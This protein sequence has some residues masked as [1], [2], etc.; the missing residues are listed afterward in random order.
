MP[1]YTF[2]E[3]D[4]RKGGQTTS[5]RYDMRQ[6]GRAGLQALANKYFQGNVKKAGE[7]LSKVGNFITD[8]FPSNR[9]WRRIFHLP[10]EFLTTCLGH[11]EPDD[12]DGVPF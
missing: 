2:S 6:R 10:P 3:E 9:A 4:R 12:P 11:C 1:R 5:Q 8:P 7:G